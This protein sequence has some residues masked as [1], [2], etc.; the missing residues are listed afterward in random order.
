[1]IRN[2]PNRYTVEEL[3]ADM[4]NEGINGS[5]DFVYMP[6]DFKTKRNRG[7][8]FVNFRTSSSAEFFA[9]TFH[10]KQ[11]QRYTTNKVVAIS[12]AMTQGLEANIAQYTRK[13]AQRIQN[14][15]FRPLVFKDE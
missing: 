2:V 9:Q 5:F 6:M 4:L 15:W 7:Y 14:P 3:L 8:G 11:L 12:A 1:M 10:G 13:D